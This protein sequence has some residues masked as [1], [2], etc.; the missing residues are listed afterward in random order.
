MGKWRAYSLVRTMRLWSWSRTAAVNSR[1]SSLIFVAF[2]FFPRLLLRWVV[3]S[4]FVSVQ[5]CYGWLSWRRRRPAR[6]YRRKGERS[7][8]GEGNGIP[9]MTL[10]FLLPKSKTQHRKNQWSCSVKIV[11][12]SCV[13]MTP[14]TFSEGNSLM[15]AFL[16]HTSSQIDQILTG[17]FMRKCFCSISNYVDLHLKP[18]V[19]ILSS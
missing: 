16:S 2:I 19:W 6:P 14:K 3:L 8:E 17:E 5:S 1:H 9:D 11:E 13:W 15:L 18:C 12:F 7:G 10:V 4:C